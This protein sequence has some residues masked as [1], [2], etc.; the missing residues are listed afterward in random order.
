VRGA[1]L[2]YYYA[3]LL[4]ASGADVKIVQARL[5]HKSAKTTLDTYGHLWCIGPFQATPMDVSRP[6]SLLQSGRLYSGSLLAGHASFAGPDPS[7]RKKN[8]MLKDLS[9]V[10]G[11]QDSLAK[12]NE[13][14]TDVLAELKETNSERLEAI[15]TA[16]HE[17]NSNL[18]QSSPVKK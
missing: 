7:E 15:A 16:L 14:L 5:R 1:V 10:G 17:L 9:G 3:S 18:E 11:L 2:V 13:L 6:G 4:I 8:G 12:T